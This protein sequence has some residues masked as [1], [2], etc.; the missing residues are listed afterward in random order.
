MGEGAAGLG[1]PVHLAVGADRDHAAHGVLVLVDVGEGL[2]QRLGRDRAHRLVVNRH[3]PRYM[4]GTCIG[5][6][7]CLVHGAHGT[8]TWAWTDIGV[9]MGVDTGCVGM[10]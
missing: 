5:H 9:D 7:K 6:A 4:L 1:K 3:L 8:Y 2:A 10:P